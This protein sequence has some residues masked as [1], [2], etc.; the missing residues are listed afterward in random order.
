MY[1]II[2]IG[3]IMPQLNVLPVNVS[4]NIEL[5]DD[6]TSSDSTRS[7][8]DFSK[9]IDLHLNKNKG[10]DSHSNVDSVKSEAN[11][12]KKSHS[13]AMST[14]NTKK[15]ADLLDNIDTND[16]KDS[17]PLIQ[18]V[19][20][21]GKKGQIKS[22]EIEQKALLES[23]QLM[24]FL[25]KA[26]NTLINQPADT[27]SVSLSGH[28]LGDQKAR[29]ET[30][31]LLNSSHLVAD[32]SSVA[33]A[34]GKDQVGSSE[35]L[36]L[37]HAVIKTSKEPTSVNVPVE[38]LINEKNK[39][40]MQAEVTSSVM[41]SPD[42]K[43]MLSELNV[44]AKTSNVGSA[45]VNKTNTVQQ[46][47]NSNLPSDTAVVKDLLTKNNE[48]FSLTDAQEIAKKIK[49]DHAQV[50][51]EKINQNTLQKEVIQSAK[52]EALNQQVESEKINSNV[53]SQSTTNNKAQSD[54]VKSLENTV[55][56]IEKQVNTSNKIKTENISSL[57]DPQL[58]KSDL[59]PD[60]ANKTQ[61]KQD[62]K[63]QLSASLAEQGQQ[64]A[65][66]QNKDEVFSPDKA[67][68]SNKIE[69]SANAHL[70]DVSGKA[71]QT[72]QHIIEQ[73]SAEMLNPSAATEVTQSQKTNAQ[74]HQETISLFRKDFTE[75]VKDKVMLI[76]SQKLQRFDITLDPPELGNMQVRVN[77][78]GEQAVV[79]FLVQSQQT[80]DAL[81][82]NMNKLRELL[83]EQGVDVGDANV[84]QQSANDE[85]SPAGYNSQMEGEIDNM[86]EANDVVA[87]TLSAQLLDS[88]AATVDYYA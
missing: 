60:E 88:S 40:N 50:S 56:G 44:E 69:L 13:R 17:A 18:N 21:S 38:S 5:K 15:P 22:N 33:K 57:A 58:R 9:Y 14:L 39:D 2:V 73:Q 85:G 87:H 81:E 41:K 10:T 74:L 78:Q 8:G 72:P 7:K 46:T 1:M 83:A 75:A 24:S 71:T 61:T 54:A 79:S 28:V 65:V 42:N 6:S 20:A 86:A 27:S 63:A 19:A 80:K 62:E 29:D 59:N 34:L 51:N 37:G 64:K 30:Q 12:V 35:D 52:A 4:K 53:V 76:I 25:T 70:T 49:N 26:D 67:I 45:N 32:L 55:D 43:P 82:Q 23:E 66:A 48:E 68:A 31:L 3:I 11:V 84:E 36:T 47:P 16:E 77:L